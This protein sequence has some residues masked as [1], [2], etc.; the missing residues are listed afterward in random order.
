MKTTTKIFAAVALATSFFGTQLKAQM[1]SNN[2][3]TMSASPIRFGLG[4][5]VGTMTGNLRN[6]F[7]G[8]LGGTA[9]LQYDASSNF[10]IT[11]TSGYYNF[12]PKNSPTPGYTTIGNTIYGTATH[13]QGMIPVKL[14][15]KGFFCKHGYIGAEGGVGF[16]T[17]YS[18]NKKLILSPA[19][20]WANSQW[21]I[22]GRYENF[23]GQ[24]NSYGFAAARVAFAF[25]L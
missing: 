25:G 17:Q 5:E 2:A 22:S 24:S 18:E 9:R 3:S 4:M 14:G 23:S 11:L 6:N 12:F 19:I 13:N 21:D 8:M 15:V 20:G 10:A 7:S 1:M 16:E